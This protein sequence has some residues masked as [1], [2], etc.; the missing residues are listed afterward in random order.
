MS[1]VDGCGG[2]H[3]QHAGVVDT[4]EVDFWYV[5]WK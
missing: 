5:S 4:G 3:K 2:W 1:E